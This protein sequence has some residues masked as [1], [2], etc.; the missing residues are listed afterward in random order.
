MSRRA[1]RRVGA[2]KGNQNAR[3][4]GFY[5]KV[6][7]LEEQRDLVRAAGMHGLDDE[8]SMMR[9]KIRSLMRT[10]PQNQ[11]LLKRALRTLAKLVRTDKQLGGLE[12]DFEKRAQGGPSSS[13]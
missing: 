8:I 11:A 10:D 3:R 7:T 9:V 4:H 12:K 13:G 1:K 6:R 5:S 2:P